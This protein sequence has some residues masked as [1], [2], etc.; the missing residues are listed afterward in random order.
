[1]PAIRQFAGMARSYKFY[2]L[3]QDS[4]PSKPHWR[5][6]SNTATATVLDRFMLRLSGSIGNRTRRSESNRL[7]TSA[8]KPRLSGPNKKAS[9]VR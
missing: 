6:A 8:G 5:H 3:F 7:S 9:P 4:A 1:M 2:C